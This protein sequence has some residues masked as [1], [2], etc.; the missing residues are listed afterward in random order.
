[1]VIGMTCTDIGISTCARCALFSAI[2]WVIL[3]GVAT[4]SERR[5]EKQQ[6][7]VIAEY[8]SR[9]SGGD[10]GQ[11]GASK[12][13]KP[14]S[15]AATKAYVDAISSGDR[16]A[17]LSILADD[18]TRAAYAAAMRTDQELIAAFRNVE[19]ISCESALL[20]GNLSVV[21]MSKRVELDVAGVKRRANIPFYLAQVCDHSRCLISDAIDPLDPIDALFDGLMRGHV[22]AIQSVDGSAVDQAVLKGVISVLGGRVD[23]ELHVPVVR[24]ESNRH[25]RSDPADQNRL[26]KEFLRWQSSLQSPPAIEPAFMVFRKGIA[27]HRVIGQVMSGEGAADGPMLLAGG[28]GGLVQLAYAQCSSGECVIKAS[29]EKDFLWTILK[30]FRQNR[31]FATSLQ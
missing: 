4:A 22:T 31:A 25:V 27:S 6:L 8:I 28:E 3:L 12:K 1:M 14:P 21:R 16:A 11:S 19:S 23:I 7:H 20:V 29:P 24:W 2:L 26:G 9:C 15:F 30:F 18:G 17:L 10:D 13:A 5:A